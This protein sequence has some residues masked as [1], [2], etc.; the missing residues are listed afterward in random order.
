M[1]SQKHVGGTSQVKPTVVTPIIEFY[2][3]YIL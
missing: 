3:Y 1:A 2:N